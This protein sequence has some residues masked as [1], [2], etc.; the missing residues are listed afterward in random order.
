MCF[1][2][3]RSGRVFHS[4]RSNT[5]PAA[6][7]KLLS[8]QSCRRRHKSTTHR[9]RHER[10]QGRPRCGPSPATSCAPKQCGRDQSVLTQTQVSRNAGCQH[11]DANPS[12]HPSE[13]LV[14]FFT[15]GATCIHKRSLRYEL[16]QMRARF[17]LWFSLRRSLQI[18]PALQE[19]ASKHPRRGP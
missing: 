10:R 8:A 12:G 16:S 18:P 6:A 15:P 5:K 7:P 19:G 11:R 13:N 17:V 2:C 1:L 4:V 9:H 14:E 3:V